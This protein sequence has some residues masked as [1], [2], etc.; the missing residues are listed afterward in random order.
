MIEF[1]G[2]LHDIGKIGVHD[3]ILTKNGRLTDDEF[4]AIKQHPLIGEKIVAPLGLNPDE[5]A[6]IRSHHERLDGRGYPDGLAGEKIPF[7]AR[8]VC[9][10][11]AFDAMTTTRSYRRA[12]SVERAVEELRKHRGTQFDP[13]VVEAALR[14]IELGL[15]VPPAFE[16]PGENPAAA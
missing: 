7:L 14:A 4:A 8:I 12:L 6:I 3:E 5:R 13:V 11:D 1:A 16:E 2:V 10:A 9:V 15:I